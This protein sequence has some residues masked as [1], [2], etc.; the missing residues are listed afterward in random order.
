MRDQRLDK[1]AEVLVNYSLAAKAGETAFLLGDVE[2]YPLIEA[3]YEKFV[4]E[5][6]KVEC[7]LLQRSLSEF[8]LKYGTE[9]QIKHTPAARLRGVEA[10][11]IYLYVG[12]NSNSKMLSQIA[13]KKQSLAAAGYKPILDIILG[14]TAKSNFRWCTTMYPTPSAAQDAEMGNKSYE[15]FSFNAA[16][17]N[18]D[19]PISSW[20]ALEKKQ[21]NLRLFLE[22]KQELR[23]R[24]RQGTDLKVDI[25]GMHWVNCCGKFNF[26]DGEVFTGPNLK[27]EN[28]GVNGVVRTS[29]PTIYRN[30][31][32]H[33]IELTFKHGAVTEAKAAKNEEFLREMIAQDAGAKFV[34]E[35]AIGTNF[36]I[37]TCTKNI[38]Y[39]E[40]IGGTFH[41][42]LGKGYPETGNCNESA[43]HW[44]M[45][46][47][48]RE[49]G[50]IHADGELILENGRF[51]RSDWPS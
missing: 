10:A 5:G 25:A 13:P 30:V 8:L 35:I 29:M 45:I 26:P 18:D 3:A 41:L 32:V 28:G 36:R 38:L 1:W 47:D 49:G 4:M 46:F 23:F 16:F 2:A 21:E 39:D 37:Q 48:L 14:R 51:T 12:A 27:A 20:Q 17:L 24:N 34:G 7:M 6:V 44:D 33:E 9:E 43:L 15:D 22:S 42:A 50:T 31:E 19:I 11:D 40:K